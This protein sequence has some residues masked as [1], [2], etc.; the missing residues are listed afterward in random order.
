[1]ASSSKEPT[2]TRGT[3]DGGMNN[4]Y[5]VGLGAPG[6]VEIADN[7]GRRAIYQ[8]GDAYYEDPEH[9][10]RFRKNTRRSDYIDESGYSAP[11]EAPE[12]IGPAVV[13]RAAPAKDWRSE[14]RPTAN[15]PSQEQGKTTGDIL[16]DTY[17][18][19]TE[20]QPQVGHLNALADPNQWMTQVNPA[21]QTN[22]VDPGVYVNPQIGMLQ[23]SWSNTSTNPYSLLG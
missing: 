5:R 1:M 8:G 6:G 9:E 17:A 21:M 2:Y 18:A 10:G 16:G 12:Q 14:V 11:T 7:G 22:Y 13:N 19:M 20:F 3:I 15:Q 23:D 4:T